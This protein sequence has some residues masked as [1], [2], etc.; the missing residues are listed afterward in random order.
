MQRSCHS[1]H[2]VHP[3]GIR[4]KSVHCVHPTDSRHVS[5]GVHLPLGGSNKYPKTVSRLQYNSGKTV[6]IMKNLI[7]YNAT[8]FD[9]IRYNSLFIADIH[10]QLQ[11]AIS[12]IYKTISLLTFK[13]I[14]HKRIWCI[15][16]FNMSHEKQED[17][18]EENE[19]IL[20]ISVQLDK[21]YY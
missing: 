3:Q 13:W 15:Y 11:I 7:R 1:T 9:L 14:F 16:F 2:S 4:K 19:W 6:Y 8:G 20:T 21:Q 17:K 5:R 18:Q 10:F 12:Q